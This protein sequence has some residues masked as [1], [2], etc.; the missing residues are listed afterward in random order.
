M[1]QKP[2]LWISIGLTAFMLFTLTSLLQTVSAKGGQAD[3]DASGLSPEIRAQ[4]TA[5]EAQYIELINQANAQLLQA[6]QGQAE[7]VVAEDSAASVFSPEQAA[8]TADAAA[9]SGAIRMGDP[10]LVNFEGTVAYEVPY[11]FGNIYVNAT[12]GEVIFNGTISQEPSLITAEQAAQVAANYMGNSN[13][14]HVEQD[15]L[16]GNPVFKVKFANSDAVFVDQYGNIL[17]V[18]LASD[19]GS[20]SSSSSS[21]SGEEDHDD[22]EHEEE[23][24]D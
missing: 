2:A 8:Q 10:E 17:L 9:N 23:H 7:P 22:D 14:L 18:R 11:D 16:Y 19:G 12:T 1:I 4:I 5:R 24:D 3:A 15:S 21:S 20:G 13:V 6:Q